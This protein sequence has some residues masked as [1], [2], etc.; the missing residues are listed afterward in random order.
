VPILVDTDVGATPSTGN[1][2]PYELAL[3]EGAAYDT[4]LGSKGWTGLSLSPKDET[5]TFALAYTSGTTA[6]PK[7]VEYTH[8]GVYLACLANVIESGL[9]PS[10]GIE[11]AR[12]LWTLPLF[13]AMGW[14]FP[15][16]VTAVRGTHY[17]LRK[18]D[19]PTIWRLLREEGITHFNAAPT[20]CTLLCADPA[21][22]K[23]A[24]PGVRVTVA[25]SPPTA[26]LF[27][28]MEKLDLRP[29]HVYERPLLT[30]YDLRQLLT[31]RQVWTHR[32][33]RSNYPRLHTS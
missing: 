24:E 26:T 10:A 2:S 1:P 19:Y 8:R 27:A 3:L 31:Y 14:T 16:A 7:G 33:L 15:F 25:A 18:I 32:D 30:R 9:N 5:E 20:V 21:A 4:S 12:Y 22:T 28:R 13:H 23:L 11:R 6:R 17:C 29:V